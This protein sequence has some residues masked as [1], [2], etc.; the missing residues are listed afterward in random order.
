[1]ILYLIHRAMHPLI[2]VR[3]DCSPALP[4]HHSSTFGIKE[5]HF[6]FIS[7]KNRLNG[8]RYYLNDAKPKAIIVFFHGL[9]DGRASYIKE[10][11]LLAKQGYWVFAY[12]NAGSNES[13]GRKIGSMG[14]TVQ[15]QRDFFKYLDGLELVKDLPRYAI[16]HSW[17]GYGAL[18]SAKPEYGISKIVS[19][20]GYVNFSLVSGAVMKNGFIRKLSRL[21]MGIYEGKDSLL[22]ARDVL[23]TSKAKVLYIGGEIDKTVLPE[24]SYDLL[25]KEFGD[26]DRFSFIQIKESGHTPW[27][28]IEAQHY[29]YRLFHEGISD[30]YK[31]V[32]EEMDLDKATQENSE[33]MKTIF[34]FFAS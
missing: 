9:G 31:N 4:Y 10:I 29:V 18:I 27:R 15:N 28:T 30:P 21:S 1:M 8:S 2:G 6:S 26:D 13:E 11:S 32:M 33:V 14:V 20:A 23:K 24:I 16:G 25:K 17:G 3:Y 19:L 5:E 12:D 34:D 7:G 22:D